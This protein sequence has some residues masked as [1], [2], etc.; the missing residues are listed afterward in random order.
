MIQDFQLRVL[1]QVAA[2]DAAIRTC[3]VEEQGVNARQL[4]GFRVIRR[5]IDA[6]QRQIFVNLTV[7]CWLD[8]PMAEEAFQRTE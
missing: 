7:R 8:E 4:Q 5:S 6:R 1:P 2:S 3:L